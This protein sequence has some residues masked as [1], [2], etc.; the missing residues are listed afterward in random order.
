M[1]DAEFEDRTKAIEWMASYAGPDFFVGKRVIEIGSGF[2]CGAIAAIRNGA[3]S[4]LGIEPEPFGSRLVQLQG[5]DP[6]YRLAY[7]RAARSIDKSKVRFFEG[8]ADEWPTADFDACIIADVMEHV[9]NPAAIARDAARLLRPGGLVL[10]STAPLF[11]S[12]TGHHLFELFH[13]EPWAH[14]RI[15]F[16][17][18]G[19]R[20]READYL[21]S[22]FETLN[23]VTHTQLLQAFAD[24]GLELVSERT[25]DEGNHR[26]SDY[27][28]LVATEYKERVPVTV[29]DE[30]VS[31]ILVR[32]P[33][34]ATSAVADGSSASADRPRKSMLEKFA[35]SGF[36]RAAASLGQAK[37]R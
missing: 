21:V 24:A 12:A 8:Y 32:K 26:F 29:F 10:A 16:D 20:Q 13:S 36:R 19:L 7:E 31:Q 11:H 5:A 33:A 18:C 25:L 2:G 4:Y 6:G 34:A 17:P 28:H 22:E 14:L 1:K 35:V 37:P 27:E 9:G 15:G 30:C 23:G 3:S